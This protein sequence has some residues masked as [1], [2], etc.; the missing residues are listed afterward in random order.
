M[1][2][3]PGFCNVIDSAQD[4]EMTDAFGTWDVDERLP[5]A[6]VPYHDTFEREINVRDKHR[7]VLFRLELNCHEI[8]IFGPGKDLKSRL[9][10]II[11]GFSGFWHFD[12]IFA[13]HSH[14]IIQTS[15]KELIYIGVT[16][17]SINTRHPLIGCIPPCI[18][19]PYP[20]AI[21]YYDALLMGDPGYMLKEH[22]ILLLDE[23]TGERIQ[24]LFKI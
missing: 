3:F 13:E 4:C 7:E 19:Q 11:H 16:I 17:Y 18:E 20:I 23:F 9:L 5:I 15:A 6:H 10:V 24:S 1:S 8:K 2:K 21:T 12:S 14:V 22:D